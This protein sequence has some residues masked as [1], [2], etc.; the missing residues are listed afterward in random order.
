MIFLVKKIW[1]IKHF[2]AKLAALATK[3]TITMILMKMRLK[4]VAENNIGR[5]KK[6][7][8]KVM[9]SILK[10]QNKNCRLEMIMTI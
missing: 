3:T 5:I 9:T 4:D 7:T 10:I 6:M 1:E 8:Q 2:T